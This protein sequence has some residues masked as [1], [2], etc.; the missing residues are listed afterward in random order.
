MASPADGPDTAAAPGAAS[1]SL[2]EITV[3]AQRR[4]EN[5]QD[6]PISMQALTGETLQQLNIQT[7]DDYIKYLPNVTVGEQRSRARTRCSCAA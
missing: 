6:V 5:M 4:T 1:D 7:F 3:T 2:Q